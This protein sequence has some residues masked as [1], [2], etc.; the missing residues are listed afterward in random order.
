MRLYI[1]GGGRGREW[2]GDLSD[3]GPFAEY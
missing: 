3:W 2:Y 1:R